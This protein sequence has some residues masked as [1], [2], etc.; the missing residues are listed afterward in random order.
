MPASNARRRAPAGSAASVP[1]PYSASIATRGL[2]S[3]AAVRSAVRTSIGTIRAPIG[4]RPLGKRDVGGDPVPDLDDQA[5]V[6][7]CDNLI[8]QENIQLGRHCLELHLIVG[9]VISAASGTAAS[10]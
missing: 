10:G 6:L 3:R 5:D 9:T 4:E 1:N 7:L 2:S 8:H